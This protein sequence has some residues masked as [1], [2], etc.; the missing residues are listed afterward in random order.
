M[1]SE[2]Q[3]CERTRVE[4]R[5]LADQVLSLVTDRDVY[6]RWEK[7]LVA[8]SPQLR[9]TH[10]FVD[11]VRGAYIDAMVFRALRLLEG[12]GSLSQVLAR[13]AEYPQLRH[14]KVSDREFADDRAG[15]QQAATDLAQLQ[16]P[17]FSHRERTLPALESV[18]R[19]LNKAL[20]AMSGNLQTYY[21]IVAEGHLDM[22][23]KH[24]GDP[25]QGL[26]PA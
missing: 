18:H 21:W 13:I 5:H 15:L 10:A 2:K 20:D 11:M 25:L 17:H 6:L 1:L 26:R 24:D 22:D 3:F 12:S 19:A 7:E 8:T 9:E 14:D 4:L 23:V 16:Q